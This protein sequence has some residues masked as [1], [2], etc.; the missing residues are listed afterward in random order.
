MAYQLPTSDGF[1]PKTTFKP[2]VDL[3]GYGASLYLLMA[4]CTSVVHEDKGTHGEARGV[5][6][7]GEPVALSTN[8]YFH[9]IKC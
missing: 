7:T 6:P 4:G 3:D 9:R 8:G 2:Y 1:L 5:A